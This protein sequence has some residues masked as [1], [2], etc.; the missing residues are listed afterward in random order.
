MKALELDAFKTLV[1]EHFGLVFEQQTQS[2]L[3]GALAKRMAAC[4][5]H[6]PRAYAARLRADAAERQALVNLL[7]VNETYFF[8][9]PEQLRLLIQ[10][11]IPRRLTVRAD[12]AKVRLLSAGCSSGEEVYS[13]IML[14]TEVYGERTPELFEVMG[15][16]ID[17]ATLEKARAG[18]YG[19]FSFRG[20]SA[21]R[22]TRFFLPSGSGYQVRDGILA[23]ARFV[24]LNLSAP[25][26]SLGRFDCI[27]YRNVSIY[28]DEPTRERV[29]R[30]LIRLLKPEGY[31]IIGSS[32]TLGNDIGLLELVQED[33]LFYFI[34]RSCGESDRPVSKSAAGA[35]VTDDFR[36]PR[37]PD[38]PTPPT[39][40]PA[41]QRARPLAAAPASPAAPVQPTPPTPAK[42]APM[43]VGSQPP[44]A[45]WPLDPV[46]QLIAEQRFDEALATVGERLV[47][48]P[49]DADALL[50]SAYLLLERRQFDAAEEQVRQV[51]E[52]QPWLTDA[53]LLQGLINKWREQAD[54]AV[55]A[56]KRAI[57][58]QPDCWPAHFH[59]G[60]LYRAR[61]DGAQAGRAW[62]AVAR[63]LAAE[64]PPA[65]GLRLRVLEPPAKMARYLCERHL[66][67]E[68]EPRPS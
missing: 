6:L 41:A 1:R 51:L 33:G 46:Q 10:R 42:P 19:R 3:A 45:P 44:A 54:P 15:G 25:P 65:S 7:T 66:A 63:L 56:F 21:E 13:L 37:P 57:Y 49:A 50:L 67:P 47:Q 9:E 18:R 52:Q 17:S 36:P 64:P 20:V 40:Q 29:L 61:G 43:T 22:Q 11:L 39:P 30:N 14:L 31:L 62:S 2:K 34:N 32:E 58:I 55:A 60:D 27:L 8:R 26:A 4:E 48:A 12:G 28:F 24:P 68:R 59:L 16:D 23:Q 53:W 35:L 5:L 38:P